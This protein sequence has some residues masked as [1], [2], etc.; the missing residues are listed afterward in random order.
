VTVDTYGHL[1][2]GADI[3]WVDKLDAATNPQPS[4]TQEQPDE[5]TPSA[6]V[7]LIENVGGPARIRT[8]DQRI[9][10]SPGPLRRKKISPLALQS[11]EKSGR[12]CNLGATGMPAKSLR[13]CV[14]ADTSLVLR[15][16]VTIPLFSTSPI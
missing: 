8:L 6:D 12:N 7:Q 14:R 15:R 5:N 1:V 2:P 4:A 13:S 16:V 10:S 11:K 3:A 9:M